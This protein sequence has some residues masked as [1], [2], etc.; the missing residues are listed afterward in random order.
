[1]S[2]EGDA[3]LSVQHLQLSE[4]AEMRWDDATKLIRGEAAEGAIINQ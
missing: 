3:I 4:A 1:M 2:M